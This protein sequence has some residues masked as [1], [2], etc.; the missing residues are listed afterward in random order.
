MKRSAARWRKRMSG[1][2]RGVVYKISLP[3]AADAE[4][5]A[6]ALLGE[7]FE[8]PAAIETDVKNIGAVAGEEVVEL[9]LTQ[10]K[11]FETPV[12][13]LAGFKRIRLAPSE[14]THV[15]LI[16]DPRSLGQVDAN[17]NRV[18]VPG[19]YTVS[20]G[21]TQPGESEAIQTGKFVVKG[22]TTLPK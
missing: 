17:G 18:I 12:R 14:S 20:V 19:E 1:S 2:P 22:K 16:V 5:A 10:P 3:V 15:R 4:D 6:A 11:G 8:R 21:S 7:V 13:V 9:Y